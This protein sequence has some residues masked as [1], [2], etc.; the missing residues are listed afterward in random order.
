MPLSPALLRDLAADLANAR[1]ERTPCEL[2]TALHSRLVEQG[3][4]EKEAY[5]IQEALVQVELGR[6][7]RLAGAKVGA[8]NDTAQ[9]ALGLSRR[10]SA[11]C[12]RAAGS[13]PTAA[14]TS[15]T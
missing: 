5:Q 12:S 13:R 4:G 8:A 9:R 1:A 7:E 11:G 3:F 14:S 2:E 10:S 15:H 6:G